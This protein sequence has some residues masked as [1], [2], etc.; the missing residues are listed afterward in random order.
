MPLHRDYFEKGANIMDEIFDDRIKITNPGGLPKGFPESDFGNISLT[1]NPTIA[2]LLLRSKYI[3][4]MG[5]G[6]NRIRKS[7]IDYGLSEPVFRYDTFFHV[8]YKRRDL[9]NAFNLT[10]NK[11]SSQSVKN[12]VDILQQLYKNDKKLSL[13][14]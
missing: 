4:K 5:T 8:V 2:D 9:L 1:R 10:Y 7:F 11:S 12:G 13:K 14:K 3:E 6:I